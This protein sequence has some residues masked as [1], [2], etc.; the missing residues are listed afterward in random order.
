M[1]VRSLLTSDH[2]WR[3]RAPK[4]GGHQGPDSEHGRGFRKG[5]ATTRDPSFWN[6]GDVKTRYGAPPKDHVF[7]GG[8]QVVAALAPDRFEDRPRAATTWAWAEEVND[9][10]LRRRARD[11]AAARAVDDVVAARE[12]APLEKLQRSL[13]ALKLAR[14]LATRGR[15]GEPPPTQLRPRTPGAA[16]PPGRGAD[17]AREGRALNAAHAARNARASQG[18]SAFSII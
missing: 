1:S 15:V 3:N 14:G 10:E 13:A 16:P 12:A 4:R 9:G 6:P 17:L 7:G 5:Q 2:E 8:A 18:H 11:A